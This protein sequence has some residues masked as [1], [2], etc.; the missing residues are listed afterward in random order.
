MLGMCQGWQKLIL[1]H[2]LTPWGPRELRVWRGAAELRIF[3]LNSWMVYTGTSLPAPKQLCALAHLRIPAQRVLSSSCK[4]VKG[5]WV[6]FSFQNRNVV[7]IVHQYV[8]K[9]EFGITPWPPWIFRSFG[10]GKAQQS[11][12]YSVVYTGTSLPAPKQLCA[13]AH[14]GIP[15][16]RVLS[17]VIL[18]QLCR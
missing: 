16:K 18:N 10:Y 4:K 15:A 8:D 11:Y 1:G 7:K 2:S 9:N 6:W 14:L 12:V 13:L 3:N 5:F 17:S